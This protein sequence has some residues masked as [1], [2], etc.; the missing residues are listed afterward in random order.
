MTGQRIRPLLLAMTAL[1]VLAF[2]G[3]IF[4]QETRPEH[5][6][7]RC[8]AL[9][10]SL[11]VATSDSELGGAYGGGV[12]WGLRRWLA[13]NADGLWLPRPDGE[14]RFAAGVTAEF[15]IVDE[16][17]AR[18]FVQAG[19]GASVATFD[20]SRRSMPGFYARRLA[21]DVGEHA[22]ARTFTDPALF[23]GAGLKSL[24]ARNL[25]LRPGVST[26]IAMH[27]GRT[28]VT[29]LITLGVSFHIENRAITP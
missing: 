16:W 1:M 7:S 17:G 4:A 29:A 11:G 19:L 14:K 23:V 2:P 15:S 6:W 24:V 26:I 9:N 27:D 28:N 10:L 25:E 8:S 21:P 18:P 20:L 13:L 12:R 5:D 3:R 22:M